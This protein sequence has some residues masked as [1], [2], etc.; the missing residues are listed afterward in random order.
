MNFW[1]KTYGASRRRKDRALLASIER[2]IAQAE[3]L[4]ARAAKDNPA[5]VVSDE[6]RAR[7]ARAFG[8]PA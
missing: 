2:E 1:E 5:P 3:R 4:A 7:I 6:E 8:R